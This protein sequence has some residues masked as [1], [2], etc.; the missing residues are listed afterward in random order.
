M[1]PL[2]EIA[3]VAWTLAAAWVALPG[4]LAP[5]APAIAVLAV[6]ALALLAPTPRRVG[7][8]RWSS[9]SDAR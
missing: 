8:R 1:G 2:R 5:S 9:P 6:S 4:G 7:R 3:A